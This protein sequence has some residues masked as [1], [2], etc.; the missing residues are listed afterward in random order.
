MSILAALA[1]IVATS[2]Q[3]PSPP[4]TPSLDAPLIRDRRL[5]VV[6]SLYVNASFVLF[7][8]VS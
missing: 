1:A 7:R 2:T 4:E 5:R 6:V 3:G 8:L